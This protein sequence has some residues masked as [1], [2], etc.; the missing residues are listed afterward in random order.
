MPISGPTTDH[1]EIRSWADH[2]KIVPV[3]LLPHFIAHEPPVLAL[4]I[5]KSVRDR[6]DVRI[7]AWDE[8][9]ARFDLLGL[10]FI[11]DS[12]HSGYN[13][14]LQRDEKSPHISQS[15]RPERLSN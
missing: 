9:F 11:Y 15:Y 3:E 4:L 13:E 10:A 6:K 8:F 12:E 14:L 2:H 7:L 5:A 1:H